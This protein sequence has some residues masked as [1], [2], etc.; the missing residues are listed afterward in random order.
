VT[1]TRLICSS[2]RGPGVYPSSV[3]IRT[4]TEPGDRLEAALPAGW[5]PL[6]L[7]PA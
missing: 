7:V 3:E 5:A 1:A 4:A 6:E 2:N